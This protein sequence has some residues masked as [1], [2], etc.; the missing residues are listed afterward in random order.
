MII[1]NITAKGLMFPLDYD[2]RQTKAL[3]YQMGAVVRT[4]WIIA[5]KM[6]AVEDC[7]MPQETLEQV[8]AVRKELH[9]MKKDI[10]AVRTE[11]QTMREELQEQLGDMRTEM[12]DGLGEIVKL[13]K[14]VM[15]PSNKRVRALGDVTGAGAVI[16]GGE[17]EDEEEEEGVDHDNDHL[18]Q[19]EEEAEEGLPIPMAAVGVGS[20]RMLGMIPS[21]NAFIIKSHTKA[22]ELVRHLVADKKISIRTLVGT[23]SH[24]HLN[25]LG[26]HLRQHYRTS[27]GDDIA[28]AI[29]M[30]TYL[31]NETEA[32]SADDEAYLLT[33]SPVVPMTSSSSSSS[34]KAGGNSSASASASN[35]SSGGIEEWAADQV[36]RA[37]IISAV[38]TL[39]LRALEQKYK[40]DSRT[41]VQK[42]K[43]ST[44]KA[45]AGAIAKKLRPFSRPLLVASGAGAPAASDSQPQK[46]SSIFSFFSKP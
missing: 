40:S 23:P 8:L 42:I 16:V 12:H 43:P 20:S 10:T 38:D 37:A 46:A 11:M 27:E 18:M 3:I 30:L 2:L 19:L 32:L 4:E 36:K 21:D 34:A 9:D 41:K 35:T 14:R 33:L 13:L 44:W 1:R 26:G 5:N 25:G 7:R 17:E 39:L 15:F 22:S 6:V 45:T 28:D 29:T 24:M 31:V